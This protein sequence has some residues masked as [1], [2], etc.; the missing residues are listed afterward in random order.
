MLPTK[1]VVIGAGSA[2]FGLN[3]VGSLMRSAKLR[4]SHIALVDRNAEDAGLM[5]R[6]A[7]RLN[8]EW[9][10]EMT[11]TAHTHH[12]EALDGRRLCR[13]GHRGAAARGAVAAGLRDHAEVRR[14][15]ALRRERRAGRLCPRRPQ[16]RAGAGDRPRHGAG[17]P[18]RLV[19][20]L[21][22]PDGA[23][24]RRHHPLQQDQGGRAVPPDLCRL[25]HGRLRAG[26]RAGHRGAGGPDQHAM[27]TRTSGRCSARWRA[28]R[29]RS[30]TSRPPG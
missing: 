30:W 16:H 8:R 18:G 6:L 19:H 11:I 7:E 23:H 10:A 12:A 2:S 24:L 27:P 28:R 13:L 3:T 26:R 14:A 20:Q 15:P 21:H 17:L 22:Q 9:D 25:R 1:I 5:R 29:W 4:G